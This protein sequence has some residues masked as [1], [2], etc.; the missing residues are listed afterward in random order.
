MIDKDGNKIGA[1]EFTF[2][3]DTEAFHSCS[4]VYSDE[5]YIFGGSL[6]PRQ[7]SVSC[8]EG[9]YVIFIICSENRFMFVKTFGIIEF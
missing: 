1:L 5:M 3:P 7:I 8:R 4:L 6:N 9:E 2:E